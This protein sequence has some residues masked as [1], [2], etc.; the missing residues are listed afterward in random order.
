M[1]RKL[2]K[3]EKNMSPGSRLAQWRPPGLGE[4]PSRSEQPLG[5][6]PDDGESGQGTRSK[7]RYTAC[8]MRGR[9]ERPFFIP[10]PYGAGL[11]PA[12]SFAVGAGRSR[13]SPRG[14]SGCSCSSFG[15]YS[16][17]SSHELKMSGD[18]SSSNQSKLR[19]SWR[20]LQ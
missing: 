11:L 10:V 19:Y 6:P 4:P 12:T 2:E 1:M 7:A 20:I 17:K 18:A 5:Q 13:L 9:V 3:I 8:M 15:S 16:T 14:C